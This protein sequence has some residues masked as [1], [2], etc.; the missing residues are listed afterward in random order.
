[1]QQLEL[2]LI[3]RGLCWERSS[4]LKEVLAVTVLL[5]V[6]FVFGFAFDIPISMELFCSPKGHHFHLE[7]QTNNA[8]KPKVLQSV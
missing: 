5:F 8:T 7:K 4:V 1:M 6:S 3:P 2:K